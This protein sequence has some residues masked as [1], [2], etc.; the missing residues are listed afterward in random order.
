[1]PESLLSPRKT[2]RIMQTVAR[3]GRKSAS[4]ALAGLE[5]VVL[6]GR[7]DGSGAGLDRNLVAEFVRIRLETK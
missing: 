4:K 2:V 6:Y 5:S 3:S 7:F 1:M